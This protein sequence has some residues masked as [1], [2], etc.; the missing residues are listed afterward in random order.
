MT[1]SEAVGVIRRLWYIPLIAVFLGLVAGVWIRVSADR[2]YTSDVNLVMSVSVLT[3]DPKDVSNALVALDRQT[4]IGTLAVVSGSNLI[5]DK[6]IDEAGVPSHDITGFTGTEVANANVVTLEVTGS[7]SQAVVAVSSRAATLIAAEFGRQYPLYRVESLDRPK[8]VVD[9]GAPWWQLIAAGLVG[10]WLL[11]VLVALAVDAAQRSRLDRDPVVPL[12]YVAVPVEF[13]RSTGTAPA[14]DLRRGEAPREPVGAGVG[15]AR[16]G[17]GNGRNR[18]A[19]NGNGATNGN[20][21]PNGN[22]PAGGSR[23]NGKPSPDQRRGR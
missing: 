20:G 13:L 15:A 21:G 14:L 3:G 9:I 10:G 18:S 16:N 11:G 7:S 23:T 4:L 8:P 6:A 17:S 1:L 19:R 2:V 5:E 22:S 12:G